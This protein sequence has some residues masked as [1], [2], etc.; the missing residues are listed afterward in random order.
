MSTALH[1]A[2]APLHLSTR[3]CVFILALAAGTG[4]A[5][6]FSPSLTLGVA[7][8]PALAL[9]VFRYP[10]PLIVLFLTAGLVKQDPRVN[11]LIEADLTVVFGALLV[12]AVV[13]RVVAR[14]MRLPAAIVFAIPMAVV[15]AASMLSPTGA[16]GADKALRFCTLTLLALVA[17]AILADDRRR[18]GRFLLGLAVLGFAASL[19]AIQSQETT[20]WGRLTANGSNPISLARI[21]ALAFAF[22]WIRFHF[23]RQ[24]FERAVAIAMLAVAALCVLASGSRGPA[25]SVVAGFA[26][27]SAITYVQHRRSI[28]GIGPLLVCGGLAAV[29]LTVVTIPSVPLY[30]FQLLFS[31]E[32]GSSVIVRGLIYATALGL[33]LRNPLGIGLGGF[34]RYALLDLRY[35][36]NML[37]EVGCE[38]G[39]IPLLGL[40][41]LIGASL[42]CM[43][44]V[45]RREYSWQTLFLAAVLVNALLNAMVSGD[46][47]DNRLFFA[48]VLLPFVYQRIQRR[49]ASDH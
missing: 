41:V 38:M 25:L 49:A 42:V 37:L 29:A 40:L 15:S 19:T 23:A 27:I 35:P 36:H 31:G 20:H 39:W 14:P 33:T 47:N 13:A 11:A 45:L 5:A 21:G 24:P 2:P 17:P 28:I 1:S 12:L 34:E 9:A 22:G 8:C 6:A 16:Y 44:R 30:R 32:G 4:I 26:V 18:M 10:E 7:L 43:V 3:M 48:A 46:L